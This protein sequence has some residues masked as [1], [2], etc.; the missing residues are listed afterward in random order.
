MPYTKEPSTHN[1]Q[2]HSCCI[3]LNKEQNEITEIHMTHVIDAPTVSIQSKQA[4]IT[5]VYKSFIRQE[6]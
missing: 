2:H 5:D 3:T 6:I 4:Q 1:A